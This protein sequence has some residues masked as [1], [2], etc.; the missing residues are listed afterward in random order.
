MFS[1]FKSRLN[2]AIRG[3]KLRPQSS[4]VVCYVITELDS[5][6]KFTRNCYYLYKLRFLWCETSKN[7]IT[8]V[9]AIRNNA[10]KQLTN[11]PRKFQAN[12]SC[13]FVFSVS[14]KVVAC[15]S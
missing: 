3:L 5:T 8:N 11:L 12:T 2:A 13:I 14:H 15:L 4:S 6:E 1:N 10:N 9:L 7:K